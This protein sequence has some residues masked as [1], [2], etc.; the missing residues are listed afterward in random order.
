MPIHIITA[1]KLIAADNRRNIEDLLSRFCRRRF[2]RG[3]AKN[4]LSFITR[5]GVAMTR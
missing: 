2:N 3:A 4:K 5:H 1:H